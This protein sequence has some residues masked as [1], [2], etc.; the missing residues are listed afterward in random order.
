MKSPLVTDADYIDDKDRYTKLQVLKSAAG[1]YIGT[2]Y[3]NPDGYQEPGSR[4]S[5][6]FPTEEI[7]N[8]VF[9]GELWCQRVNP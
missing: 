1:W 2:L 7:A 8:E 5:E 9:K 6:Y 3:N 4:D